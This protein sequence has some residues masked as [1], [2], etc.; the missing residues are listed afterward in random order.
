MREGVAGVDFALNLDIFFRDVQYAFRQ[1]HL[2]SRAESAHRA[3][4]ALRCGESYFIDGMPE[5]CQPRPLTEDPPS[6]LAVMVLTKEGPLELVGGMQEQLASIDHDLVLGDL[7]TMQALQSAA[8]SQPRF[9]AV[10]FGSFAGLALILAVV[11]LYGVLAQMVAQRTRE[12][13]IRMAVGASRGAVLSSIFRRALT[14]AASGIVLGVVASTI[15]V[16]ALTGLLLWH[17]RGECRNVCACCW[18][19]DAYSARRKLESS[20]AGSKHRSNSG[21]SYGI[22]CATILMSSFRR[23]SNFSS[24]SGIHQEIYAELQS[25]IDAD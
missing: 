23:I 5:R 24:R 15:A 3:F 10:L 12:I 1:F 21:A 9:R 8:L 4:S 25:H 13:A 2:V 19:I 20:L 17:S 7:G 16:R 11:G 18:P 14:L 6:S 22:S